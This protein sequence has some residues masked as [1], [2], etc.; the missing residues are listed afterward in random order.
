MEATGRYSLPLALAL[1]AHRQTDVMVVNPRVMKSFSKALLQRAKTDRTDAEVIRT[2]AE[3]MPFV[4]W[5]F[6]PQEALQTT[7]PYAAGQPAE[8]DVP[9]R[10]QSGPCL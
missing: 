6:P 9:S 1:H 10:N 5:Q 4:P 7:G 2:L 3:K 8:S